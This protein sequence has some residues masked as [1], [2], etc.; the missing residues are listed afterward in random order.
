MH[1]P[2]KSEEGYILMG[3]LILLVVFVI[4]MAVAA[5][6]VADSIQRDRDL[7][8]MQRGRQY[9]R[10]IQLYYRKFHAYPP[11]VD[12]LVKTQEIRFLR[13]RYLDPAT[14][15]DDWKPVMFGQNKTPMAMGFFGQP[16]GGT[17]GNALSGIGPG[18]DQN[19]GGG[20]FGAPSSSAGGGL[21]S[22]PVAGSPAQPGATGD[23]SSG[24]NGPTTG[25]IGGQTGGIGSGPTFGGAGIIGVSPAS[26][27]K[28]IYIFKK[29][30]HYNEWEFLYSPLS[31]M[32]GAGGAGGVPIGQPVGA[33]GAPGAPGLP[34]GP[35]VP[36][37]PGFP[38]TGPA[39]GPGAGGINPGGGGNPQPAPT[40]PTQ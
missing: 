12:A 21:F 13:R 29:K 30:S 17:G 24:K 1:R 25:G 38:T 39:P 32:Q 33:P 5:P 14:G 34:G 28:S 3:V 27:K 26:P 31:E 22:S 16:L 2:A 8:T 18:G 7:E 37:G 11:N 10:A 15:K 19:A 20:M 23:P 6:K 40:P 4:A 36:G 35:G 9:M